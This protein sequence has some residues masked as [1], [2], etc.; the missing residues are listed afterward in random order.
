MY[1]R[2]KTA[3]ISGFN[4]IKLQNCREIYMYAKERGFRF[5]ALFNSLCKNQISNFFLEI[6]EYISIKYI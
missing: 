1:T 6:L 3:I 4:F 2:R 5:Q